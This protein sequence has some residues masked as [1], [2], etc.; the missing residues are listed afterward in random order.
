LD[1]CLGEDFN[2]GY[3]FCELVMCVEVL[4][5]FVVL[6][7]FSIWGFVS[8]AYEGYQLVSLL[9]LGRVCLVSLV[10]DQFGMLVMLLLYV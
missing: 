5:R 3:D 4:W 6:H 10:M 2:G 1:I 9:E 8:D 7:L